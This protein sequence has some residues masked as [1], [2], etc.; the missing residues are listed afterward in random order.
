MV[1]S[2]GFF[3]VTS[4]IVNSSVTTA[5]AVRE[6]YFLLFCVFFTFLYFFV[7]QPTMHRTFW[8]IIIITL[9]IICLVMPEAA[10]NPCNEKI[11]LPSN[12]DV[13][14]CLCQGPM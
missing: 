12:D 11:L 4:D 9:L 10:I 3:G 6:F 2:G 5:T 7:V 8:G 1:L 13:C 14:L